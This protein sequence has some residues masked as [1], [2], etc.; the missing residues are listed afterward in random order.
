[1]FSTG[2][3]I[4]IAI[5]AAMIILGLILCAI[6]RPDMKKLLLVFLI[7]G[8]ASEIIKV[9]SV[10]APERNDKGRVIQDEVRKVL[11]IYVKKL[12]LLI[13]DANDILKADLKRQM[14]VQ[15]INRYLEDLKTNGVTRIEFPHGKRL[16]E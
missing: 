4:F 16:F 14:Q 5:S 3:L 13:R 11:H 6:I 1:M 10:K 2:H 9:V 7:L 8:A 12:P 15:A